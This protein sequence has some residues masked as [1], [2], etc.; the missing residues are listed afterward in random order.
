MECFIYIGQK[1]FNKSKM[2]FK[3]K[4][5]RENNED[6]FDFW[7]DIHKNEYIKNTSIVN[8]F[9]YS[10]ME[11]Y[12]KTKE[13]K[14]IYLN[15]YI[16]NIFSNETKTNIILNGFCI[17]QK[18][19]RSFSKLAYLYKF[20]KAK[21]VVDTDLLLND[22]DPNKKTVISI[23]QNNYKYL[24]TA[25][26]IMKLIKNS[27]CNSPNYFS[28]S[29][30]CK[31][32][33]NNI[34]FNKSTLYNIYFFIKETNFIMPD[35]LQKYFLSNFDLHTFM[36]F[37]ET[38][39]RY[40]SIKTK[41]DNFTIDETY[42][43]IIAMIDLYNRSCSNLK[44]KIIINKRIPMKYISE[45]FKPY[46]FLFMMYRYSNCQTTRSNYKDLMTN[47][48]RRF[49]KLCKDFGKIIMK[50]NMY[51]KKG[52]T[53]TYNLKDINFVE[54]NS[55]FLT[56]HSTN[57]PY[58]ENN[59]YNNGL[60][61]NRDSVVEIEMDYDDD[62]NNVDVRLNNYSTYIVDNYNLYNREDDYYSDE[63]ISS[64][65]NESDNESD[66]ESNNNSDSSSDNDEENNYIINQD[67]DR[68]ILD[69]DIGTVPLNDTF[70]RIYLDYDECLTDDGIVLNTLFNNINED[71]I[72]S[73]DIN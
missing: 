51:N 42:S 23:L 66:N 48:L 60:Y 22:L 63:N 61:T 59:H 12:D 33:Y 5:K 37:N 11:N 40:N 15:K 29:L 73:N 27:I 64:N 26:D 71:I 16:N 65:S 21:T 45:I 2:I 55:N 52:Y 39:I 46:L 62:G 70:N 69:V 54:P 3:T 17:I 31:N 47:K 10:L 4:T 72:L 36:N 13:S 49:A 56:N 50:R 9:L 20:K 58:I 18:T 24:F 30:P 41:F 57:D 8:I 1:I 38:I 19:Y 67:N 7:D 25:Q 68:I 14:F 28:E 53:L 6:N 44:Q 35:Y 32:P 34:I 43:K